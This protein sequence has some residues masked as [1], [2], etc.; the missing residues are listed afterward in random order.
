MLTRT[1]C[2]RSPFSSTIVLSATCELG[3]LQ[4][5]AQF[6]VGELV[7]PMTRSCSSTEIAFYPV[8]SCMYF[9]TIT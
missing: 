5:I 7:R 1:I 9:C 3:W 4:V 8:R 6:H 2:R